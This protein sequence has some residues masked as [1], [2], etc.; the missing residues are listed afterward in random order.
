MMQFR[1]RSK[2]IQLI[3]TVY[4]PAIKRGR[5]E[6]VGR[7]DKDRPLL[8]DGIR[9]V[10]TPQETAEIEHYLANR[11]AMIDRETMRTAA[12]DL[13]RLMRLAEAFF[14]ADHGDDGRLAAM[15]IYGAW[16]DLK[17][18]MHRAG[19]RKDGK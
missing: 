12:D 17:K 7:L 4:D 3:R 10:C 18:A 2:V 8:D 9:A 1:E 16:D 19:Y 13:P 15:E 14:R 11:S 6:V 5:T